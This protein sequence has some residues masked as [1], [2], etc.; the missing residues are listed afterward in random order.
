MIERGVLNFKKKFIII[1]T[2][3]EFIG[4]ILFIFLFIFVKPLGLKSIFLLFSSALI[5][6]SLLRCLKFTFVTLQEGHFKR[7]GG[8]ISY[9]IAG[10]YYVAN[11]KS[12]IWIALVWILIILAFFKLIES[13]QRIIV[14]VSF[15]RKLH[16]AY[17]KKFF[18]DLKIPFAYVHSRPGLAD[19]FSRR[20][21]G[22]LMKSLWEHQFLSPRS[23]LSVYTGSRLKGKLGSYFWT[24]R[25]RGMIFFVNSNSVSN[26]SS[27]FRK[28]LISHAAAFISLEMPFEIDKLA[29]DTFRKETNAGYY[30]CLGPTVTI[31]ISPLGK[32]ESMPVEEKGDLILETFWGIKKLS[33]DSVIAPLSN[34]LASTALPIAASD[35]MLSLKR[36]RYVQ[37]ISRYALS[38]I[39]DSYLRF[40]LSHS[41]VERFISLIDCIES[42]IRIS[43][44]ILLINLWDKIGQD[45]NI[46]KEMERILT[47]GSWIK[48][49]HILI[50]KPIQNKL[51]EEICL[52]WKKN[53]F[54]IQKQLIKKVNESGL[55]QLNFKGTNQLDW[56]KWF[57]DFRNVT[58]GHGVVEEISLSPYWHLMHEI[59]LEM[60]HGIKYLIF[61]SHLVTLDHENKKTIYRGWLRKQF[62]QEEDKEDEQ[63]VFLDTQSNR[64]VV[65]YPLIV[66]KKL[67]AL[68]FD[69]ISKKEKTIDFLNYVSGEHKKLE[70]VDI[71]D[72]DPYKIWEAKKRQIENVYSQKSF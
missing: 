29:S 32:G 10:V 33:L 34:L 39:S 12:V 7:L 54:K 20:F 42:L 69:H 17:R 58:R 5:L 30:E 14:E 68:V 11:S 55:Y 37:E 36:R 40:R 52:F 63:F 25:Q 70:F 15:I 61:S 26:Y 49:L 64:M 16:G 3:I 13:S 67:Y 65:L 23:G 1:L 35:S 31:R 53:I 4:G 46:K 24:H 72:I 56:I 71:S 21:S 19:Y 62:A 66:I 41:D 44:V 18:Q 45:S 48:L 50:K 8:S 6:I 28:W 43:V 51:C 27:E 2:V 57:R 59:F 9:L 47:L 38:P 60:V 22:K